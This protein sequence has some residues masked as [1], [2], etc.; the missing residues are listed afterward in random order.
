MTTAPEDVRA[1]QDGTGGDR[2]AAR[3]R[4]LEQRLRRRA[5]PADG[6]APRPPGTAPPL[7]FQQERVWFMEQVAPGSGAYH[8]AV[9]LRLRGPLDVDALR[10]A[11]DALPARHEVLRTTFPVDAEGRPG[12]HVADAVAVPLRC[13]D[14]ADEDAARALLDAAAA[15]PFDL[16]RGPLLRALLVRLPAG[17]GAPPEHLL[18]L[19]LHHVAGD[20]WSVDLLQR[21]LAAGYHA[22]RTG[23]GPVPG[24][25][26]LGYGDVAAWQRATLTG[27]A[28]E[29]QLA[30]WTG[31]LRGVEPLE[32]PTDRPRP[33]R[34]TFDG[35]V[36]EVLLDAGLADALRGLSRAH[37][38][39]L[40][41]TLLAAFEVLLHRW[42][43]QE[44]FAVG[45]IAAGRSRRELDDVVGM[46]VT[47]LPIAADL[48]GDPSFTEHLARVRRGVLDAFDHQ[49][50]PFEQ[51]VRELD[52]A[53]DVS[54]SPVFQAAFVLQNYEMGRL[55]GAGS[56][57]LE[58]VWEPRQLPATRFDL[59]LHA[60][61]VP[62]GLLVTVVHATA[63]FDP[64]TVARMVRHL[65]AL[66]RAA[67]A[68][69]DTAV[70]AL[71]MTG[72]DDRAAVAAWNATAAP[73]PDDATVHGLV[74]RRAAA[75]PDAVAL[76]VPGPDRRE[77]TYAEL[78]A[79]A[80][81][82]ARRLRAL[83]AGP[84]TR[85]AVCVPRSAELVVALLG[86]LKSGA[87][88]VPLDPEYPAERL[89]SMLADADPVAAVTVR[90]SALP[91]GGVPVLHAD[92]P[93]PDPEDPAGV[94][95]RAPSAADSRAE[96]PAS[97]SR[98][99]G[100]GE[101]A[102][103]PG[104]PAGPDDPAYVIYTSGST[105]RP[106][107]AVNAHRGVVNRLHWMQRAF[108]LDATDAV[109]QKT[110]A[111]F[112]VSVWEFFWPLLAGARLVLA[113]PG[114]HRDAAYLWELIAA[115][116]IT[117][118]HFVPS[119]LTP[120]LAQL[121]GAPAGERALPLR[122]VVCSGEEL[123]LASAREL[124]R[125]LP[126][127]E[128]HNLYGPT[129]AAVD[130]TAFRCTPESLA[131]VASVP[132]GRPIDNLRVHVVDRHGAPVPVG[133]PG[134]LLIAG[135]GVGLGYHRRPELT[136]Q[137]FVADPDPRPGPGE[138]RA[139]RTGDLARRRADGLLEFL[140][141]L[142][143]QVKIRGVRIEPGELDAALRAQ[144]GVEDVAVVV[145]E[146]APG[147][148]R[149]VAY[150]VG[151][152]EPDALR[153]ACK[154]ALPEYL[155]PSAVVAL[156]ALPLT[157]NGKLDRTA[158]PA[159]TV[160]RAAGTAL[161]APRDGVEELLAG[162]WRE[163]LALPAEQPL[164]ID[165][166]FFDLGGHS[167]L[168]TQLVA[169]LRSVAP[170]ELVPVGV[171]DLFTH[172]T[173]REL[174]AFASAPEDDG[175][176]RLL[177][178]LTA[179]V[180]AADR[181]LTYVA[182]PYGGGSAIVYEPLAA[183]LPAG[184]SLFS[185]AIPGHDVGLSDE[186]LAFDE[187][188]ARIGD[189]VLERV[190]GPLALYGHCGVGNAIAFGVARYLD[191]RGRR[192]EAVYNGAIFPFARFG[193][194]FGQ[195]R[196]RLEALRS[197]RHYASW[198]KGMGVDTDQL[199]PEQADRIISTMRADSRAAEEY[200]TGLLDRG[201]AKLPAP[202]V[203]VVGTEDPV[204]DYYRER[205]REW[206]FLTDT[207]AL[208]VLDRAGHFFVRHR[209]AELAEILTTVHPAL[210]ADDTSALPPEAPPEDPPPPW[211]FVERHDE[212]R[213]DPVART[214][215]AVGR[216]LAV[217]AGQLISTTGAALAGFAVPIWLYTQTGSVTDLG[218]LWSLSL[219]CG[220]LTLPVA[221]ALVDRADRRKIMMAASCTAGAVELT[222]AV[223][224]WSGTVVLW[225]VYALLAVSAV[226]ASFQRIAFQSSI[227]QLVP[228]RYLGHAMGIAQLTNG[229][230][231]LLMPLV[232]AG[233]LATISLAGVLGVAVASYLLA[234]LTL[235]LVRF[236]D[237][238]GWRPREPLLTAIANG[239]AY[240]W[241]HR[242]FRTMLAYFALANVFLA[243]A[244]VLVSPLVLS[245]GSVAEVARVALAEAVGAVT[246]GVAMALWGGPRRR[247]MAAVL[248]GNAGMAVGCLIAGLAPALPVVMAGF[249]VL[250]ACMALSQGIYGT[251]VQVKVPQ[252]YHGR[253]FAI[254][255]T[256]TWST[257]PIG[258]ALLAPLSVAW[259]E[260]LLAEGGG[261][262]GTVG[263]VIG[264]GEG[265]G[266]GF[267]YVVFALVMGAINLGALGLR[268]LRRF[269]TEV[270]DALADDL[271]GVQERESG[272]AVRAPAVRG[273]D[274]RVLTRG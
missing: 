197:N 232:A 51:L 26:G 157:P 1:G 143:H 106:K 93:D 154:R 230:A 150:V 34:Q 216:F 110:P 187:L 172:R 149:L 208:V 126:G 94:P 267:A 162:L 249:F 49:D 195:L 83:G 238:L 21:D 85:V 254:N 107:G 76:V 63:L 202:V 203:S 167:L 82:V 103:G 180:A 115:E 272:T 33:A 42:S 252:R 14:A 40:Y 77:T 35:G 62:D 155:V 112:D 253:V 30:H 199:E 270:P 215:P 55:A 118:A 223:L 183:A 81:A 175:P 264:T 123:P 131:G 156:P 31:E 67:V 142:D 109:L 15:E 119:M 211:A 74:E 145:R 102:P 170:P 212:G 255:Q 10:G 141:R 164:G 79:A 29:R 220:V 139:Y 205:Y 196:T 100:V 138:G 198:L 134:E 89:A 127:T 117:T 16:A 132:L 153:A 105:G 20:G 268:V 169:R 273:A 237:L 121:D 184:Y 133:V 262:A 122:R 44:R 191:D 227:P 226:A 130:V 92:D 43:R 78:D 209:A 17:E 54:R 244:L 266:I 241:N 9:P 90:D 95:T 48:G 68:A 8:I 140:G 260:P 36:H 57:D 52:V 174:A 234:V 242:G 218:L 207:T 24:P 108:A 32:L 120:F 11:L 201:A 47:T 256:I 136:A 97:A 214:T 87:A 23:S 257:L 6:I 38:A 129:E 104:T 240:S 271:V 114:G 163:V 53:R 41:M 84:G 152:A 91:D 72:D 219:V 71:P 46:F 222:L 28:L 146:D 147:D 250:G 200:F 225:T 186:G 243:P 185:V 66:L 65:E 224:L 229:M 171:M 193:G 101:S 228:K 259:F 61:E 18:Q 25:T 245:F 19:A 151:D 59:E 189:E 235:A 45:T 98:H 73:F 190:E 263:Q 159:P 165:D 248:L 116:G 161:V 124:L 144:P 251:L 135:V 22:L 246:G 179:P 204:T 64:G 269:D 12:A 236:P 88:Y 2:A 166:D 3:R 258:F 261:L 178:E 39:T 247:R 56:S 177:H 4:L 192:I 75:A 210:A 182:V 274:G 5:A 231:L 60:V 128:L 70:S 113:A 50:V 233:L 37:G 239:L 7:S 27:P 194:R 137:R 173:V 217:A 176:R 206:G 69:P 80:D 111:S 160:Q 86:V 125:L 265:R 158:L 148:R 13:A 96:P 213:P 58:L 181:V 188:V 168:A 221:G 99:L